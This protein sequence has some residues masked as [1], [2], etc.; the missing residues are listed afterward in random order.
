VP[1]SQPSGIFS[2]IAFISNTLYAAIAYPDD[3]PYQSR[4]QH[5]GY[6]LALTPAEGKELMGFIKSDI[7][8]A[9]QGNYIYQFQHENCAH[10]VQKRLEGVLEKKK[11]GGKVP[12][13]FAIPI[14]KTKLPGPL[15]VLMNA[16]KLVP[17]SIN[18]NV[19]KLISLILAPWRS[20]QITD[21]NG[22]RITK[23]V[24]NS[25]GWKKLEVHHPAALPLNI[26][27]NRLIF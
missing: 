21:G 11:N 15:G 24:I 22:N 3:N 9:R 20:K 8:K 16:T 1:L 18:S 14:Q 12:K 19:F 2:K 25:K 10:W 5:L 6:S 13:L 23:S 26:N 17:K 27:E 7:L 4:R